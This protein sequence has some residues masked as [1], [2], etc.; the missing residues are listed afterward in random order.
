[1]LAANHYRK[2]FLTK[3]I[4]RLDFQSVEKLSGE[5]RP[6][7]SH[8]ISG[9]YPDVL[10]KQKN[11]FRFSMSSDGPDMSHQAQ[12]WTWEH[13]NNE[14]GERVVEISQTHLSMEY[15]KSAFDNFDVFNQDFE[16]IYANFQR[17]YDVKEFNRLGLRYINEINLTEGNPLVWDNLI[18]DGLIVGTKAGLQD[19]MNLVRSMH[20]LQAIRDEVTILF[21]YGIFNPD[22]P[23]AVARKNFIL[24][25][26]CFFSGSMDNGEVHGRM[27]N[28]N[29]VAEDIFESS[30]ED[31]LR[32][33]MEVKG[34]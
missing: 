13:K 1:M 20:Q 22:F 6:Q 5:E 26:D 17:L 12:G 34:E 18:N 16:Y 15:R 10:G 33:I 27:Q 32:K 14:V 25:I 29:R 3:V 21:N 9:R 30:I 11:Q 8:E 19:E 28:A 31:G 2:D 24:D 23:N 4:V 7:F